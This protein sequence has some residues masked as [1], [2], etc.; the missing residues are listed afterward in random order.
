MMDV[1]ESSVLR[2]VEIMQQV[3]NHEN[4]LAL[5]CVY[6]ADK[7]L[8]LVMDLASHGTVFQRLINGGPYSEKDVRNFSL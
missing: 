1:D 8:Y 3:G 7:Q 2:E 4:I 6:K 5:H